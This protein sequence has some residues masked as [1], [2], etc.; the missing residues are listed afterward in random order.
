MNKQE[1]KFDIGA[2][3]RSFRFAFK[4]IAYAFKAEHN[5]WIHL[6]A[7]VAAVTASAAFQISRHDWIFV[8]IAIALVFSAELFNSAI[9]YMCDVV[10]PE[11]SF[12]VEKAKDIA[13]AAVLVTALCAAIIGLAV[14]APHLLSLSMFGGR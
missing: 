8:I 1:R 5:M 14:F 6:A 9:E 11:K 7:A 4:G 3:A 12:A 10:Q 2:R 13:A